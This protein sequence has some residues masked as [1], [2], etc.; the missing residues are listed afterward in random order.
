ML[1]SYGR[2]RDAP[3]S[4]LDPY[5]CLPMIGPILMTYAVGAVCLYSPGC[6]EKLFGKKLDGSR[7]RVFGS[8]KPR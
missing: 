2:C 6:L 7:S 3:I 1:F 8:A 4:Y 5:A